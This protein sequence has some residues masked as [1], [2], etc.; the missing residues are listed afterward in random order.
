MYTNINS[1]PSTAATGAVAATSTA[2][3]P[4]ATP[5]APPLPSGTSSSSG[6]AVSPQ[7]S[8]R[9]A[10]L[11]SLPQADQALVRNTYNSTR[12]YHGS[13]AAGKASIQQAGFDTGRKA[14]GATE[15]VANMVS[16]S[17]VDAAGR[18]N[19]LTGNHDLAKKYAVTGTGTPPA[20][21]RAVVD[22][23]KVD[24]HPDPD[25]DPA[26]NAVRTRKNIP[27]GN[28]L[29]SKQ[30]GDHKLSGAANQYFQQ[31]LGS[32]GLQVSEQQAMELLA[33]V[34]SDSDDDDFTHVTPMGVA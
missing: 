19:Y 13:S 6:G 21:V 31:Q 14:G 5:S 33:D 12:L 2:A 32:K 26:D 9:G 22:Q 7:H 1:I 10:F 29:Q 17:F 15:T 18:H 23:A 28:I 3:T 11:R 27:S 24:L 25:S 30:H 20:I 34:Q 16:Q 4:A 8:G